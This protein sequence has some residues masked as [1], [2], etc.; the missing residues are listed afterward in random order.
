MI[1]RRHIPDQRVAGAGLGLSLAL[2]VACLGFLQ[3]VEKAEAVEMRGTKVEQA[4]VDVPLQAVLK[5]APV[6]DMIEP[7]EDA[8][9]DHVVAPVVIVEGVC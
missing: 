7:M 3:S 9:G 8:F 6:L 2:I 1:H 5:V 4:I